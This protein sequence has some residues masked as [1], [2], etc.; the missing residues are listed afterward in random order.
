MDSTNHWLD[1]GLK[2]PLGSPPSSRSCPIGR[3]DLAQP[4][5]SHQLS[6]CVHII[7][8]DATLVIGLFTL[9]GTLNIYIRVLLCAFFLLPSGMHFIKVKKHLV[10][11]CIA[12]RLGWLLVF[13]VTHTTAVNICSPL[14]F[15]GKMFLV[16]SG[17]SSEHD[18]N[19]IWL[20]CFHLSEDAT[21][22]PSVWKF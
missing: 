3:H 21:W 14:G 20:Q 13:T 10:C 8:K 2:Q 18:S 15:C 16:S 4:R 6:A 17:N 9:H 11:L 7:V 5:T 1:E 22:F 19:F 12:G